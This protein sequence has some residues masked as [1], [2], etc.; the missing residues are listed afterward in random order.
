MRRYK[1]AVKHDA[2]V[3]DDGDVK[4]LPNELRFMVIHC[5]GDFCGDINFHDDGDNNFHDDDDSSNA[6]DIG[7]LNR[8][9]SPSS[10][11]E[12]GASILR[13]LFKALTLTYCL[14]YTSVTDSLDQDPAD[15]LFVRDWAKPG[16]LKPFS[17]LLLFI[18]KNLQTVHPF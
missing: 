12:F 9:V 17:S 8:S 1:D 16:E 6:N 3:R 7:Y 11:Y 18:R 2:G 4:R 13:N 14:N 15:H 5:E 10:G